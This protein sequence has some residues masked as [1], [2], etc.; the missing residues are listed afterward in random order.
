MRKILLVLAFLLCISSTSAASEDPVTLG[1]GT[2]IIGED[3]QPGHYII[4]PDATYA[5]MFDQVKPDMKADLNASK[6]VFYLDDKDEAVLLDGMYIYI[7]DG[8]IYFEPIKYTQDQMDNK[9]FSALLSMRQ[10]AILSQYE[11]VDQYRH[12]IYGGTYTVGVDIPA[13]KWQ[14]RYF[15]LLSDTVTVTSN[16]VKTRIRLFSPND[17]VYTPDLLTAAYFT[18]EDGDTVHITDTKGRGAV[19]FIPHR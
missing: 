14:I 5:V 7:L 12:G 16:G 2:W 3:I 19:F 17:S 8:N 15:D 9:T 4:V 10:A 6:T 13:G 1:I 11:S 18:L